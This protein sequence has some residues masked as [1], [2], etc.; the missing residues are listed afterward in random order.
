MAFLFDIESLLPFFFVLAVVFGSLEVSKVFKNRGV[1]GL[2][3]IVVAMFAI[4]NPSVSAFIYMIMPYAII[5]FVIFF[6]L[7]FVVKF[8]SSDEEGKEKD[9]TL[10]VI[11]AGLI[12][13]FLASFGGNLSK[14]FPSMGFLSSDNFIVIIVLVIVMIALFATYKV[15]PTK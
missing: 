15:K 4:I 5:V 14:M 2:I 13:I 12:L 10:P 6:F 7:G 1:N 9:L 3:S 11:I 8:F